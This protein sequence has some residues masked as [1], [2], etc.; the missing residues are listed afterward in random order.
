[1]VFR[2]DAGGIF[3]VGLTYLIVAYA[4][5]VVM[6]HLIL[7]VLQTSFAAIINAALFNT[8]ALML[9]F[10]HLCA[11]LVDPGII[12]RNQYQ[13]IRD[14]GTTSVEV[15]AGWT[16]CNKC[17]MARPPRA[18]H[19][20]VCN[21]CVR[22]M[23]HHCPWINNCV[24]EYNQ[25]Y[26]IMFLVY[27]GLLCLYAVI[28]VIVCRAMLSADTHKDVEDTNP[29][30]VLSLKLPDQSCRRS[31]T[32]DNFCFILM[33]CDDLLSYKSIVEDETAVESIQNRTRRGEIDL[34]A[35]GFRRRL[36]KRALFQEVFGTGPVYLWLLPCHYLF[37]PSTS[38]DMLMAAPPHTIKTLRIS[39]QEQPTHVD[40]LSESDDS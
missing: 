12:P 6:F 21:C 37:Q 20:R 39:L 19:C 25:K 5:Y 31:Q 3:C 23:D 18:H 28:L 2:C 33:S 27:V 22:R 32:T 10:S 8:V 38:S 9:C 1:M 29:A 36:S 30:T 7:P 40:Q 16:V 17:A 24:G 35:D 11:V 15:P 13:I 26:F 4:D 14:S 34:E